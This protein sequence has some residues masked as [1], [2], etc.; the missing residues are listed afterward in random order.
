M[1]NNTHTHKY[2]YTY[3]LLFL[4]YIF[5]NLLFN[6]FQSRSFSLRIQHRQHLINNL[7]MFLLRFQLSH[8]HRTPNLPHLLQN[9]NFRISNDILIQFQH[10]QSFIVADYEDEERIFC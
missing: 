10:T 3:I 7:I 1:F 2:I 8:L 6:F 9:P 4:I 5:P